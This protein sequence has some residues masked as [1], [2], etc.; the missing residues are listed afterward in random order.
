MYFFSPPLRSPFSPCFVNVFFEQLW[1]V[2]F[3]YSISLLAGRNLLFPLACQTEPDKTPLQFL[4]TWRFSQLLSVWELLHHFFV[5]SLFSSNRILFNNFLPW[6]CYHLKPLHHHIR[7][8][9]TDQLHFHHTVA[10]PHCS[11]W[12]AA[13]VSN[14]RAITVYDRGHRNINCYWF[15]CLSAA[16]HGGVVSD[17]Q[18]DAAGTLDLLA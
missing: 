7:N 8:A 15:L 10:L 12:W 18:K 6:S 9:I 16:K 1:P 4:Y 11:L 13:T 17:Q 14:S 2:H 3:H 5:H